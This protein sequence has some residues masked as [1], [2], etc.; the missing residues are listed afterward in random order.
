MKDPRQT[1][2][3]LGYVLVVLGL[4]GTVSLF[5]MLQRSP[6]Q[7]AVDRACAL[8]GWEPAQV[9]FDGGHYAYRFLYS[10][11]RAELLVDTPEGRRPVVI[12]LRN[13]PFSGWQVLS[14]AGDRV[15]PS[16]HLTSA[17]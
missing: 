13:D 12:R 17:R 7:V 15:D 16:V 1:R 14:L 5:T 8:G 4:Y 3:L 9:H 10:V 11:T 2:R 6:F